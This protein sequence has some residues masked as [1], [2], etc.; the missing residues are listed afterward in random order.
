MVVLQSQ[1]QG[2]VAS[3]PPAGVG[4]DEQQGPGNSRRL[5]DCA[6]NQTWNKNQVVPL[7]TP[8]LQRAG[9][10]GEGGDIRFSRKADSR[11]AGSCVGSRDQDAGQL[12]GVAGARRGGPRPRR[13]V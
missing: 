9:R 3:H 5:R 12:R 8:L 1:S 6:E 2:S 10:W 11:P 4:R 13:P 7:P